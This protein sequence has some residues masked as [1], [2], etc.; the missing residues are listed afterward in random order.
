MR[1]A[2]KYAAQ[3]CLSDESFI[4]D[5]NGFDFGEIDVFVDGVECF[6][7]VDYIIDD[8]LSLSLQAY[9]LE[10]VS[11]LLRKTTFRLLFACFF[12]LLSLLILGATL[13]ITLVSFF[14]QG[15]MMIFGC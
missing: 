9:F 15:L 1:V 14:C 2:I 10:I 6:I 3:R 7:D 8:R 12:Y 11:L 13:F 5:V 4:E